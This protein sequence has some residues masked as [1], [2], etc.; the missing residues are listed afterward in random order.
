MTAALATNDNLQ[1]PNEPGHGRAVVNG[2]NVLN[3]AL[4]GNIVTVTNHGVGTIYVS[5]RAYTQFHTI[6]ANRCLIDGFHNRRTN[7]IVEL[8]AAFSYAVLQ[9][10]RDRNGNVILFDRSDQLMFIVDPGAYVLLAV[11]D[12]KMAKEDRGEG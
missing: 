2:V 12:R 7:V 1:M 6:A 10:T 5:M 8:A 11:F 4:T 9:R 3:C